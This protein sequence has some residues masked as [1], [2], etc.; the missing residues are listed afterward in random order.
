[1]TRDEI[2]HLADSCAQHY[3]MDEAHVQRFAALVAAA[4]RERIGDQCAEQIKAAIEDEREACAKVCEDIDIVD[5]EHCMVLHED[6]AKTLNN[7][8]A[9]IRAMSAK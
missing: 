1:M 4:E 5:F 8:A 3:W 7:A 2:M 6:A 9:A